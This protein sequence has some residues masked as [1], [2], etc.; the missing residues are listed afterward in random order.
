MPLVRTLTGGQTHNLGVTRNR[1]CSTSV[2]GMTLQQLSHRPGPQIFLLSVVGIISFVPTDMA[3]SCSW[4]VVIMT[5][6]F[7]AH[8]LAIRLFSLSELWPGQMSPLSGAFLGGPQVNQ[9]QQFS[10]DGM[11]FARSSTAMLPSSDCEA[12]GSGSTA[13]CFQGSRGGGWGS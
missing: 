8:A 3:A 10:G 11:A 9:R 13:V 4:D 1:T 2:Y 5:D 12:T 6:F 7:P